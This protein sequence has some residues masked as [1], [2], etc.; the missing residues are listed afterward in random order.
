MEEEVAQNASHLA[1]LAQL[2]ILMFI[3]VVYLFI[4]LFLVHRLSRT[5]WLFELERNDKGFF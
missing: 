2:Y 4:G 5:K 3:S 1:S